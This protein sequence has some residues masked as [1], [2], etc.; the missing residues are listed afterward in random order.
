MASASPNLPGLR[1]RMLEQA[2]E[3]GDLAAARSAAG[4][5]WQAGDRRFD[6]QLVLIVDAMRRSDWKAAQAYV[7]GRAAST[8]GDAVARLVG[9]PLASW[10]ALGAREKMPERHLLDAGGRAAPQ[11]A[12]QLEAALVQLA[13]RRPA[14]AVALADKVTLTDRTS[15][16][17]AMRVAAALDKAGEGAAAKRL[18]GRIA[19]AAGERED[20]LLL[21][22][23]QDVASARAG[24]AHWFALLADGFARTP[25][26]NPKVPLLFARVAFWLDGA[27]WQARSALVEALD[28]NDRKADALNLLQDASLPAVLAMR[29]A[30]LLADTGKVPEALALAE[31]AAAGEAPGRGL[32]VRY[33]DVARRSNDAS[34]AERAYA[35]LERDL[36]D[37]EFDRA[38]HGNILIARAELLLQAGDWDAAEPL[39]AKAV[40]LRPNDPAILNFVGYSSIERRRNVDAAFAQIEAAWAQDPQN[41]AITDS[42]GWA[43][44]LTGRAG[45]AVP[46]LE[47]AQAG[48]PGNAVIV[49]HLGDAYWTAGQR[50]QARYTWRAAALLA[51]AEMATRIEAKLRDGLTPATTAP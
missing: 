46:L 37:N 18:R 13:G 27:D 42:L 6:A 32:L 41:A 3:A 8:G 50:Y 17:V 2:I 21:L 49:E 7:A 33:A 44:F 31:K 15:Q 45:E 9:P 39:L 24:V 23:D 22:P 5:L 20:P 40:A 43:Y 12:F 11:P 34:A 10:I 19:L 30:E 47:K 36:G 1:G 35:R 48:D 51:E 29:Q 25:N 14:D 16:L 4:L 28:R 26:S 38:L